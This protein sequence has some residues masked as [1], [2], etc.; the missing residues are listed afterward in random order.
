M[1]QIQTSKKSLFVE[2]WSMAE[3]VNA[4]LG[5]TLMTMGVITLGLMSILIYLVIKP[6]PIY[7]IR[8]TT[9]AGIAYPQGSF[10]TTVSMFAVSWVLNWSN[11]T[12][13]NVESVYKHAQQFM[14]PRFLAQTRIR[15]KKDLEQVKNNNISS[16][17]SLNQEPLVQEITRGFNVTISGDKGIYMGREQIKLQKMLYHLRVRQIGRAHV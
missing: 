6:R 1:D 8:Q 17:F 4:K 11:F 2:R 9:S 15:F 3:I 16:L 7:Y 14:S 13:A 10:L 5:I 12:P